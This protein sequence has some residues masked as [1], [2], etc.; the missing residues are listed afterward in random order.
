MHPND[1]IA[2]FLK[3]VR[4]TRRLLSRQV[5]FFNQNG[6]PRR[7]LESIYELAFLR[8]FISFETQLVELLKTNLMMPVDCA[9]RIRSNFPVTNRA[10]AGKLLLGPNRYFQILPVEQMEKIA[11]VYLKNGGP[12]VGLDPTQKISIAKAY[13][14]RNHIAHK[15]TDSKYSFQKKV[16]NSVVLPRSSTSPGYYLRTSMTN[17]VTYFDHHVSSVGSCLNKIC[18]ES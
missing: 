13:A 5:G 11:K 17:N 3:N 6:L 14:I 15:S 12:F 10:Q 18:R 1:H 8:V 2:A 16:L 7:E 9:G 4:T